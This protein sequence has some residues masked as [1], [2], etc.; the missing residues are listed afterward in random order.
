M[1]DE[2]SR[3]PDS[4]E[5]RK[6]KNKKVKNILKKWRESDETGSIK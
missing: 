1:R 6:Q 4:K 2:K 3:M 5:I